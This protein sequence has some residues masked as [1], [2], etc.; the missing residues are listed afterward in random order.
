MSVSVVTADTAVPGSMTRTEHCSLS[1]GKPLALC[2]SLDSS[3]QPCNLSQ[4]HVAWAK[5]RPKTSRLCLLHLRWNSPPTD[6]NTVWRWRFSQM[7]L[8]PNTCTTP[9]PHII[10]TSSHHHSNHH[11]PSHQP[12]KHPTPHITLT[13]HNH[14][15]VY[16]TTTPHL[17]APHNHSTPSYHPIP[18]Q[19]LH[20][21]T[22]T[23]HPHTHTSQI[24][25]WR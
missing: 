8:L 6:H 19:P 18:S 25:C 12:P 20:T 2:G 9:H 21:L 11:T 3:C 4:S 13:I 10:P 22:T 15:H 24:K 17:H 16:L 1:R 5:P 14:P 23:P 7:H